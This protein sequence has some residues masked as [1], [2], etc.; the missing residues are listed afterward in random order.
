MDIAIVKAALRGE[1]DGMWVTRSDGSSAQVPINVPHDLPHLV[2]E[3]WFGLTHG[4]WGL[5]DEGA[6]AGDIKA[7]GSRDSR[8]AKKG[9]IGVLAARPGQ[10]PVGPDPL[11]RD[12]SEELQAAKAITNAFRLWGMADREP[13]TVRARLGS[14]A[15]VNRVVRE[16]LDRMSNADVES[17]YERQDALWARWLAVPPGEKL[18]LRWPCDG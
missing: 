13:D 14:P 5:I 1:R 8:R 9:R 3:S 16:V 4:F 6:F 12:H 11:L 17:V 2:V 15:A 7:A 18:R 10:S